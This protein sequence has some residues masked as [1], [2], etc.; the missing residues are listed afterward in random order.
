MELPTKKSQFSLK[1]SDR[2]VIGDGWGKSENINKGPVCK[3]RPTWSFQPG[4]LIS[5]QDVIS[6]QWVKSENIN[7]TP[8]CNY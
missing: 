3:Y 1:F 4:F 5:D 8:V 2:N 6:N 7:M